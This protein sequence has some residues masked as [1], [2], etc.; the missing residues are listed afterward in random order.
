M[1]HQEM[2][3]IEQ[4]RIF[5]LLRWAFSDLTKTLDIAREFGLP[6]NPLFIEKLECVQHM[7]RQLQQALIDE[8][9]ALPTALHIMAYDETETIDAIVALLADLNLGLNRQRELLSLVEEIGHREKIRLV[10][11]LDSEPLR[12]SWKDR[13][14][15]PPVRAKHIL[16]YLKKRRYPAMT[17]IEN[18]YTDEVK[19]LK[20]KKNLQL[21]PPPYFEGQQF[22]L[23]IDFST[24][25]EF[26][27]SIGE[28]QRLLKTPPFINLIRQTFLH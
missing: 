17:E 16:G 5:A 22:S 26:E 14:L 24:I 3:I 20:I 15:D 12:S 8:T 27:S 9:I 11:L 1:N 13:Q 2:N 25:E 10:D 23:R 18:H 6:S 28:M 7:S 4:A 21:I 19:E